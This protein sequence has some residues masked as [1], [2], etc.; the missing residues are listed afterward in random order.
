MRV[1]G[2][3]CYS[4]T[5]LHQ[6]LIWI[7][8][9]EAARQIRLTSLSFTPRSTHFA[10]V[11]SR[12]PL[13]ISLVGRHSFRVLDPHSASYV[14]RLQLDV[15]RVTRKLTR[16]RSLSTALTAAGMEQTGGL[17]EFKLQ[18][19]PLPRPSKMSKARPSQGSKGGEPF[20][21]AQ[22]ESGMREADG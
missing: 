8:R 1:E 4:P 10:D 9:G 21:S 17:K 7:D 3:K 19:P 12:S 15:R 16:A 13:A 2:L 11:G 14:N 5:E 20:R 18:P 6:S 22:L